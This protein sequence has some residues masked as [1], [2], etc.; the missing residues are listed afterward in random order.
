MAHRELDDRCPLFVGFRLDGTLKRE[1]QSYTG[2]GR[3]Y[4]SEEETT[5]LT[6]CRLGDQDYIGKVVEDRLS[7]DRVEDVRRNVLSILRRLCPEAR[8]PETME[9]FACR[10]LEPPAARPRGEDPA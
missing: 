7:T 4:V 3:H 2:A 6:I 10:E 8:L 1:L 9:I 5:F